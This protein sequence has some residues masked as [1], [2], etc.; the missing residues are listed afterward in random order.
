VIYIV[1]PAYNEEKNIHRFL[2]DVST[3]L[4]K[5]NLSH[6]IAIVDDGSVDNTAT[7]VK[8]AANQFPATLISYTPNKGVDEAFRRGMNWSLDRVK[9][10]DLIVTMEADRTGDLGILKSM[11]AKIESGS[12]V[13]VA[14]YYTDGGGVTGTVWYRK[15]LS[16]GANFMIKHILKIKGVKTYSSFYRVYRPEALR[17]V[18]EHY[19]DF[20]AEKGFPCVVELLYRLSQLKCRLDEVPMILKGDQ[21]IGKSKMNVLAT[22][23]GYL[24][25]MTRNIFTR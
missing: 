6:H 13:V 7:L 5:E 18:K 24:R 12:D 19:G 2:E 8:K 3:F 9:E 16:V 23:M 25:I 15:L 11:L 20:F 14:S 1:A 4:K 22:I 21:R 10:G 17:Q